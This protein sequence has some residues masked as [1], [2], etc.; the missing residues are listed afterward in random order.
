MTNA[1]RPQPVR[2]RPRLRKR[3]TRSISRWLTGNH[4]STNH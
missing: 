3:I 4:T 2:R 1:I